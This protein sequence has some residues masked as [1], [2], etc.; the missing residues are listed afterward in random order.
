MKLALLGGTGRTGRLL[1]DEAL[2][3]GHDLRLLARDPRRLPNHAGTLEV[4]TGDVR[5][6]Q[7][8][9]DTV[10]STQAVLSALGPVPGGAPDTMTRAA[11]HLAALLPAAGISRLVTLTGAGVRVDGDHPGVTDHLIRFLL[12]TL[13]PAVLL[14]SERHVMQISASGL[15]WT[16]VRVPRL[17]DGPV[18]PV[19]VGMVGQIRPVITRASAARFMLDALDQGTFVR[20]A[21]AIS[22]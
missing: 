15:D 8:V 20:A 14:D 16:V 2:A 19:T 18:R 7:A 5:D 11:E 3:R 17:T 6:A 21:P 10:A 9:A 4:I 12:R 1:I 13:Q 22:N